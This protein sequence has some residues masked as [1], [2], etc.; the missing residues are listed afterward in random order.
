MLIFSYVAKHIIANKNNFCTNCCM[1]YLLST[2]KKVNKYLNLHLDFIFIN[3][4]N[5]TED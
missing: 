3:L 1:H 5:Y 2:T 4:I